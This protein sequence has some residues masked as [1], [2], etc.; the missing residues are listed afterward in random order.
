[1]VIRCV[2]GVCVVL[3]GRAF[4]VILAMARSGSLCISRR[5]DAVRGGGRLVDETENGYFRLALGW[6]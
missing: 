5:G 4:G 1:M 3:I 6:R 2:G